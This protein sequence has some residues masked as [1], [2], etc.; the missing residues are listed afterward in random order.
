MMNE[1]IIKYQELH[2]AI[3][4]IA[5]KHGCVFHGLDDEEYYIDV[6]CPEGAKQAFV[7]EI[8][9]TMQNILT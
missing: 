1:K 4:K 5:I 2:S 9:S 6:D 7:I 8:V 3:S